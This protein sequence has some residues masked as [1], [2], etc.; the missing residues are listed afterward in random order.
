MLQ[1]SNILEKA[2]LR[3]QRYNLDSVRQVTLKKSRNSAISYGSKEAG[4][5]DRRVSIPSWANKSHPAGA[6]QT[7][8]KFYASADLFSSRRSVSTKNLY[9][10]WLVPAGCDLLAHGG[11]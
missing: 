5:I 7:L 4:G 8:Y 10:V 1:I 3:L 11:L 2:R 9:H 6:N